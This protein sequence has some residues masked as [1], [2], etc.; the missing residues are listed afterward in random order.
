MT[1]DRATWLTE[2]RAGIGASDIAGILGHSPWS[3]PWSIWVDKVG[4]A[5]LDDEDPAPQ[6]QLGR[7]L[8]PVIARWFT[9]QTG[10]AVAGEQMMLWHPT[11]PFFATVDGLVVEAAGEASVDDALGIF[12]AKFSG[13]APWSEVPE[14]YVLQCQWALHC[15][16]LGHA[17]L[18]AMHL[19]FGR[20]RF[21]VYEL[22]RDEV[23]IADAVRHVRAFWDDHVVA[24]IP[25]AADGHRA[26]AS[27]LAAAW[28]DPV[29]TPAVDVGPLAPLISELRAFKDAARQLEADI[30]EHENALKAALGAHSEGVVDGMLAVSW[31]QQ[32][33]TD[34]DRDAVRAEHGARYDVRTT[35]RVLRLHGRK[36]A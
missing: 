16:G 19:P 21:V 4:L 7:D 14:H 29:E 17:W 2:R 22:E 13:D 23:L 32:A 28:V 15:S 18:A 30:R 6:M 3:S 20:P 1:T 26:T 33:R 12:E 31:R 36:S 11:D 10:L 34:I 5:P 8:E 27:A 24:G 35:H 25:P 9:A